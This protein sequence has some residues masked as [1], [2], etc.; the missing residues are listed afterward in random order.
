MVKAHLGRAFNKTDLVLFH[1][2]L[3]IKVWKKN[4]CIF[5]SPTIYAHELFEKL[6][7]D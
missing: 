3:G 6:R 2:C 1:Y 4:K 7:R 5:M